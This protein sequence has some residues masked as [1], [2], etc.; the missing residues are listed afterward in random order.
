LKKI[1]KNICLITFVII[2]TT[3]TLFSDNTDISGSYISTNDEYIAGLTQEISFSLHIESSDDEYVDYISMTFPSSWAINNADDIN[4][5][6]ATINSNLVEWGDDNDWY[7]DFPP[8]D[9]NFI[10]E[11]NVPYYESGDIT[12]NYH[13]SG[14]M[15]GDTPHEINSS[16]TIQEEEP[17]VDLIFNS[18]SITPGSP[19]YEDEFYDIEVVIEN[20][21]N[22]NSDFTWLS[23]NINNVASESEYFYTFQIYPLSPE[24]QITI[25][26]QISYYDNTQ[27]YVYGENTLYFHIDETENPENNNTELDDI[28]WVEN[29]TILSYNW[30]VD[31]IEGTTPLS[32]VVNEYRDG[33]R[34]HKGV[35]I[36][37]P[38]GQ[39]VYPVSS[40]KVSNVENLFELG[41]KIEVSDESGYSE[42]KFVYTHVNQVN[43]GHW[44]YQKTTSNNLE[45]LSTIFNYANSHLHFEDWT[46]EFDNSYA[47]NP[48]HPEILDNTGFANQ[49]YGDGQNPVF[50]N[51]EGGL[52]ILEN[53]TSNVVIQ[54]NQIDRDV[55][56]VIIA[57]DI[58]HEDYRGG[59]ARI[60]YKID[61]NDWV[62]DVILDELVYPNAVVPY[63]YC[64][65]DCDDTD[66]YTNNDFVRYFITN[67][68]SPYAGGNYQ[69]AF[70]HDESMLG[71][72]T[73]TVE[74]E[75]FQGNTIDHSWV[76]EI[77]Q[78]AY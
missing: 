11:V 21:G 75:D 45:P 33:S 74:I 50:S 4:Y 6:I 9:Y 49:W 20:I 19:Q 41:F 29:M 44:V 38:Q 63:L 8:D 15:D 25:Y 73:L 37:E 76:I 71:T 22:A 31:S 72:H 27:L 34:T 28:G 10:I 36:L 39:P 7:G 65:T 78:S 69:G 14:D 57:K 54:H 1:I 61:D 48:H 17:F 42:G 18:I 26:F 24:E 53:G 16:L 77:V 62:E 52:I 51:E 68:I 35:D 3:G 55:D 2:L 60:R 43:I 70:Y 56:F 40:G 66:P 13:L 47:I 67:N 23:V 64:S 46:Y 32:S 12:V 30:P 58:I 59:L 5:K